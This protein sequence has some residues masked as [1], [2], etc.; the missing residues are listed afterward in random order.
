MRHAL[1]GRASRVRKGGGP[2][3][4]SARSMIEVSFATLMFIMAITVGLLLFQTGAA[5]TDTA[6]VSGRAQDRSVHQTLSPIAGDGSVSGAEV[7][8]AIARMG[9]DGVAIVVDGVGFSPTL[10]RDDFIPTGIRLNGRYVP[11]YERGPDGA[12]RRVIFVSQ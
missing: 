7:A 5:L 3:G 9:E 1:S 12:L 4:D 11:S 2:V 10:E 6:Y 8:Q